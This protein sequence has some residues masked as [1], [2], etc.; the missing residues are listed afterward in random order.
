LVGDDLSEIDGLK[1]RQI[2]YAIEQQY[3]SRYNRSVLGVRAGPAEAVVIEFAHDLYAHP[4][5]R[6]AVMT[7]WDRLEAM[8]GRDRDFYIE[9]KSY[10]AKLDS[11]EVK[12][13]PM[14][15]YVH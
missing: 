6:R 4:G 14:G 1:F 15:D 11:G 3:G 13:A 9:V 8:H 2:A 5:L 10:L 12:P 7:R